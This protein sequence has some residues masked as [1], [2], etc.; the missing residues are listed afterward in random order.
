MTQAALRAL[1]SLSLASRSAPQVTRSEPFGRRGDPHAPAASALRLPAEPSPR[2]E[3]S[4]KANGPL[5][6][7]TLKTEDCKLPAP[8]GL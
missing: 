8:A 2:T 4:P 3:D 5:S 7:D 6:T 1:F